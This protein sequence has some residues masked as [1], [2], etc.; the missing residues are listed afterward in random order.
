MGSVGV[1]GGNV[2]HIIMG[3][4]KW[5]LAFWRGFPVVWT[6]RVTVTLLEDSELTLPWLSFGTTLSI[7]TKARRIMYD[8]KRQI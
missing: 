5:A 3:M 8:C 2:G 4:L 7:G 6:L 1:S